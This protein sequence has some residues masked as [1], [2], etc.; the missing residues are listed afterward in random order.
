M[1][2][3]KD[4]ATK[5]GV[6][7]S[8]VSLV[9]NGR[10]DDVA[11]SQETRQRIL[12]AAKVLGY[13]RNELATAVS[14]GRSRVLAFVTAYPRHDVEYKS[15]VL[16]GLLEEASKR[17]YVVKVIYI[18][19]DT[20]SIKTVIEQCAQWQVA[21]LVT[22]SLGPF[23]LERLHQQSL[24]HRILVGAAEDIQCGA[25]GVHVNSDHAHSMNLILEHLTALGHERIAFLGADEEDRTAQERERLFREGM[26]N[27]GLSIL[28]HYIVHGD[29]WNYEMNSEL[30]RQLLRLSPRP[31]AIV[32]I[33][34]PSAVT[35]L[36]TARA[37]NVKVP[38]EI[39]V[40]GYANYT[41]AEFSDPALTTIAQ[42]L[43]DIGML[44]ARRLIECLE[45][46]HLKHSKSL[47]AAK[48]IIEGTP[49][50]K[51]VLPTELIIRSST[52]QCS[53]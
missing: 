28:P 11:I 6:S 39:S 2:T 37:M 13:Q 41:L 33:G 45:E 48:N 21:G 8:T 5:A 25:W 26:S 51:E 19:L 23:A 52:Q 36:N 32:C 24:P 34:D 31:T 46:R 3:M 43:H 14:T 30:S 38:E 12:S 35:F 27:C 4:I 42:P 20:E 9:L 17:G 18:T 10:A 44:L 49:F 47:V 7:R 16:S 15:R 22:T 29:W 1:I 53:G 50:V 40:V